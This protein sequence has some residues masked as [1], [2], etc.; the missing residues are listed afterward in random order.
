MD[1]VIAGG[2]KGREGEKKVEG[3]DVVVGVVTGG[4]VEKRWTVVDKLPTRLLE[5][6]WTPCSP[7][8]SQGVSALHPHYK[9]AVAVT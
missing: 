4:V 9:G 2:E 3:V 6:I 7:E 8:R 1:D 5:S